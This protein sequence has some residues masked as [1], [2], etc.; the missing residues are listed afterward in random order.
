MQRACLFR[1]PLNN[2]RL[3]GTVRPTMR[4]C[5]L[6]GRARR[7]AEPL[8]DSIGFF[9]GAIR[10][11]L[12]IGVMTGFAFAQLDI[13]WSTVDGGGG[14]SEGGEF[15]VSGTIGQPD[16]QYGMT[17]GVFTVD[18]GFWVMPVVMQTEGGPTLMIEPDAPGWATISWTPDTGTNWI[19]Q[20]SW[21]LTSGVWSNSPS[22][23]TNP[24]TVPATAPMRFYRLLNP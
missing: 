19:L 24:I 9:H 10:I 23:W 12:A 20:E 18:G 8:F 1:N 6:L 7:L 14:M 15:R 11:L 4:I 16:A 5:S 22:G 17:G 21:D 2:L 13:P 3:T